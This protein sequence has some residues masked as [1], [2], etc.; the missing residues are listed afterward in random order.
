MIPAIICDIDGTVADCSHRLHHLPNWDAFFA[1]CEQDLPMNDT[2]DIILQLRK[3]HHIIFVSGRPEKY[4]VAT[5]NWL[6]ANRM[7]FNWTL[8]MRPDGEHC[9]DVLFKQRVLTQLQSEFEV[10][11]K[12]VF[13]D[14]PSVIKMWRDNGLTCYQVN[15]RW[16]EKGKY[17]PGR[18][19]LLV[20]PCRAGKTT[21]LRSIRGYE[22]GN[23]PWQ[24]VSSD[25][26]RAAITGNQQ[27]HS[28]EARVWECIHAQ[29]KARI[30][31]GAPAVLDACSLR[32]RDRLAAIQ[33][34]GAEKARYIVLDRPLDAKLSDAKNRPEEV[35]RKY[36]QRFQS[37]IKDILAGD[38]NP[39]TE[40]IDL[41]WK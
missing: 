38:G 25:D 18:L 5:R 1:D 3:S 12:G 4:R 14:R 9:S 37:A 21:F 2:I 7:D 19:T 13:D 39:E 36:H 30:E 16:N 29:L 41:R 33:H 6:L 40:V 26:T 23:R 28:Q 34:S 24:V 15:D 27:D 20:G 22:L 32:R 35:I 31:F 10:E 8:H 17:T 11:I